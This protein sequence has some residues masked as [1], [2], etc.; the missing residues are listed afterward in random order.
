MSRL[1]CCKRAS[2]PSL[3]TDKAMGNW[4]DE[5]GWRVAEAMGTVHGA[6]MLDIKAL[7]IGIQGETHLGKLS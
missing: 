6:E 5:G 4:G 3:Q 2:Q 7:F 1:H